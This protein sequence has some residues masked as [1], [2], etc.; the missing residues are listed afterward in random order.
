MPAPVAPPPPARTPT[1]LLARPR[2]ARR[3]VIALACL[4]TGYLLA[5]STLPALPAI[6]PAWLL[7]IAGGLTLLALASRGWLCRGS[8]V[9]AVVVAAA[10]W[11]SLRVQHRPAD[12]LTGL[13]ISADPGPE[14]PPVLLAALGV[15]TSNPEPASAPRGVLGPAMARERHMP[16]T[17]RFTLR[18]FEA[19][20]G[21]RRVPVSGTLRIRLRADG[22]VPDTIRP[23]ATVRIAGELK[24]IE[25]GRNPGEPDWLAMANQDGV[26]GTLDVP[27]PELV[28]ERPPGSLHER[29]LGS[30]C[31]FR[32]SL[33]AR[34]RAALGRG[35]GAPDDDAQL[36]A[37]RALIAALLLGEQDDRLRD[38]S[39]AFTR[40]GLLHMV[41]ISGFNLAVMAGAAMF[42]LRLTGDRGPLEPLLVALLVLAYL[43]VLPAQAPILRAGIL[44]LALLLTESLGRRYDRVSVLAWVGVALLLFRPMDLFNLGFQL[45]FGVVAALLLLAEPMSRRLF[46]TP[47]MGL[48]KPHKPPGSP[49]LS[50]L[51]S[52]AGYA[53]KA[54]LKANIAA[55]VLAWLVSTPVVAWHT[56]LVSPLAI[57]SGLIVLP[58][59]IVLLW[60]GYAALLVGTLV[61]VAAGVSG[62]VLDALGLVLVRAVLLLDQ[63]PLTAVYLPRLWPLWAILAVAAGVLT[64]LNTRPRRLVAAWLIV[65]AALCFQVF[66]LPQRSAAGGPRIDVLAVGE[67]SCQLVRAG[68]VCVLVDAGS[69]ASGLGERIIPQALRSLGAWRVPTVI[70]TRP[71]LDAFSALPDLVVPLGITTVHVPDALL[72]MAR[73]APRGPAGELLDLLQARG[74]AVVPL[75]DAQTF[76]LGDSTLRVHAPP[77]T[78]GTPADASAV[79]S[80]ESSDGQTLLLLSS[81]PDSTIASLGTI[82]SLAGVVGR[83][84]ALANPAAQRLLAQHA[85]AIVIRSGKGPSAEPF[86]TDRHG[87]QSVVFGTIDRPVIHTVRP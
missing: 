37:A 33:H 5:R 57:V 53:A 64:A 32:G 54:G 38:V 27:S 13:A 9:L 65:L 19:D 28:T 70:I 87:C 56:G 3:S 14:A 12:A 63:M 23:G 25:P 8:L 36:P 16:P 46:G 29:L 74:V 79:L 73:N 42:L 55:S 22:A 21:M 58:L 17:V 31:A 77:I 24:P 39:A 82:G 43:I 41:A 35:A 10:G 61:P 15:V 44:V 20:T 68:G 78:P 80:L 48:V 52:G 40:L 72:T 84:R 59:T 66:W 71:T 76:P 30:W 2:P 51:L 26:V 81:A 34:A 6:T 1:A 69:S 60:V 11:F 86:D 47:I 67:G 45:S 50:D 83:P 18:V 62:V 85:D 4:A 49:R 75:L 7:G